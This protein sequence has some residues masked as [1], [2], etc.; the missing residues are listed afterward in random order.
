[1]HVGAAGAKFIRR[2]YLQD[3]SGVQLGHPT[4]VVE[5]EVVGLE[6]PVSAENAGSAGLLM[7][8]LGRMLVRCLVMTCWGS[9]RDRLR[10]GGRATLNRLSELWNH[11]TTSV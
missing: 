5:G 9:I 11:L 10:F 1:M 7:V 6:T 8:W 3:F 4:L 2:E